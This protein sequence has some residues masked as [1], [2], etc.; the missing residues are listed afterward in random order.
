MQ[1]LPKRSRDCRWRRH[2]AIQPAG[3]T[4]LMRR[5][6][7]IL[8]TLISS[9]LA[10]EGLP[11]TLRQ[12]AGVALYYHLVLIQHELS[13]GSLVRINPLSIT[14]KRG[15]HLV[16]PETQNP[17]ARILAFADWL[18]SVAARIQTG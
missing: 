5:G 7:T 3:W 11:L 12:R 10:T 8:Q 18:K 2:R 9:N 14:I 13:T 6:L 15:L 4:G 1:Y 17:D 16:F